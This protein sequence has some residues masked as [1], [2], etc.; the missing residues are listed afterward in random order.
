MK[1]SLMVYYSHFHILLYLIQAILNQKLV[2]NHPIP[3]F[4]T[5]DVQQTICHELHY[6]VQLIM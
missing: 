2:L 5:V 1:A 6:H 3:Q 4:Q